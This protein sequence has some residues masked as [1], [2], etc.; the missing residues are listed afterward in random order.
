MLLGGIFEETLWDLQWNLQ[1]IKWWVILL[2]NL[3][4]F[5]IK[6]LGWKENVCVSSCLTPMSLQFD[7]N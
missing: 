6:I 3:F 4:L 2:E 1:N 5:P 7:L